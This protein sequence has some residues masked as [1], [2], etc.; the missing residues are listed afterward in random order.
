IVKR[1]KTTS[2]QPKLALARIRNFIIPFP[3]IEE[4]N[5]IAEILSVWDTAIKRTEKII[6]AKI[7]LKKGLFQQ[8][9]KGK[10]RFP[11]FL[12]S[13][14]YDHGLGEIPFDWDVVVLK[15]IFSPIKRKN[16]KMSDNVLT[17]SG[18]HGLIIQEEFFNKRVAGKELKNYYL[19]ERGEF[20]YNR[21]FMNGY[22]FGA[23]KRLDRY[24]E[25]V[26][27]TLY[28]CFSMNVNDCC[29]D[30]YAQ[31]FESGLLNQ[32]LRSIAQV[33]AR[34][35]GL[36]NMTLGDFYKIRIP[37][38]QLKEQRLIA[39]L[40]NGI[41]KEIVLLDCYLNKIKK[42]KKGLMQKLLIGKIRVKI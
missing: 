38:P 33:G 37:K 35:H 4:Q 13:K 34:A 5:N 11:G 3:P 26:L 30:F 36:L 2:A 27:S 12:N 10:S 22:P 21:S 25:G 19:L 31:Y 40:L 16:H 18:Q 9:L 14:K 39:S 7:Q 24:D 41:D 28:I 1:E 6:E 8:L 23:I 15:K 29:K 42:Q 17:A 20:A 32:Q